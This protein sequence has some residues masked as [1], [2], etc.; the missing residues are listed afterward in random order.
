M[1]VNIYVKY[2]KPDLTHI[3]HSLNGDVVFSGVNYGI[4]SYPT[5]YEI[6]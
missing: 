4:E 3:R 6:S 1:R 5:T 2:S